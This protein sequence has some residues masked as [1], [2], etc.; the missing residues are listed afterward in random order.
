MFTEEGGMPDR[1]HPP[2]DYYGFD[3]YYLGPDGGPHPFCESMIQRHPEINV[4]VPYSFYQEPRK[5]CGNWAS[6]MP[7]QHKQLALAR[8]YNLG[9]AAF[10]W[11]SWSSGGCYYTGVGESPEAQVVHM[12]Y[13]GGR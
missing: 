7:D 6:E 3:C 4:Y 13:W 10:T 11:I 12:Q 2:V 5:E 9:I 1:P 8:K